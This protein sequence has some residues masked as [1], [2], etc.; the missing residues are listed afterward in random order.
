MGKLLQD[1][2]GYTSSLYGID[3]AASALQS[4]YLLAQTPLRHGV[5]GA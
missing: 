4:L 1:N 5:G 3:P 2:K